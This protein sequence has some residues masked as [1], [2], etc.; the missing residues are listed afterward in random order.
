M[1]AGI[2]DLPQQRT[3][4]G[5]ARSTRDVLTGAWLLADGFDVF[6]LNFRDHGDTHRLNRA[7]S[8]RAGSAKRSV[9]GCARSSSASRHRRPGL[10]AIRSAATS[11]CGS[12]PVRRPRAS[13]P[14]TRSRC[15]IIDPA[16]GLLGLESGPW[17]YQSYLHKWRRSRC[18]ATPASP[19]E[20]YFEPRDLAGDPRGLTRALVLRHT[21]FG[22][23][24]NYLDGYSIKT[25]WPA[26]VPATILTAADDPVIPSATSAHCGCRRPSNSTSRRTAGTVIYQRL[27]PAHVRGRLHRAAHGLATSTGPGASTAGWHNG[28]QLKVPREL[29]AP[30]RS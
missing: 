18:C 30:P 1:A 16:V 11:R 15:S 9:R 13:R 4:K 7:C 17:F 8:T 23:L 22:P 25:G 24:D 14:A 2:A 10:P 6:R 20:H 26:A 27:A 21:D 19:D 28:R 5:S 29:A 12:R 3:V